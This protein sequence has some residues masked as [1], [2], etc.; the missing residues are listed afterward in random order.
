MSSCIPR[1]SG[2]IVINLKDFQYNLRGADLELIDQF[3]ASRGPGN[4]HI[5][6][7]G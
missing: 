4:R 2:N 6:G 3:L 1:K 5:L 7:I